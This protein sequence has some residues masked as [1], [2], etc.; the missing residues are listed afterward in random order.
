MLAVL[1]GGEPGID[2]LLLGELLDDEGERE[3]DEERLDEEEDERDE[4]DGGVLGLPP[5]DDG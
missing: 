4:D 3:L 2:G 5:D 1:T